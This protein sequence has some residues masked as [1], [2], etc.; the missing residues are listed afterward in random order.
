METMIMNSIRTDKQIKQFGP[1]FISGWGKGATITA[2]IRYDD[3]C[4]NG[5]NTFSITADIV[6]PASKR[7][8]DIE[9]GGYLHEEI[10][11][12]F[13][14]LIPYIKWHLVSSDGPMHYTANTTYWA[15]QGNLENARSCAVWPQ[16]SLEEL[17][18]TITLNERLPQ[19]LEEFKTAVE[20]LGFVF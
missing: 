3:S 6:T 7:R 11:K 13:P 17:R 5:Y 4:R 9:A 8:N 15:N 1:R 10:A 20:S 18:D 16:A 14:E 12:V 19:L 2:H